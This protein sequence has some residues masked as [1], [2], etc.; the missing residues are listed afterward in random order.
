MKYTI[1]E[2]VLNE[3]NASSKARKDVSYFILNNGF[4]SIG[5]NDKRKIKNNAFAK[6][7]LALKLYV[8]I[9]FTLKKDDVLFLQTSTKVLKPFLLIKKLR[10]FKIIYLI[11]DM[12][13]LRFSQKESI[14]KHQLEIKNDIHLMSQ[15]D[16][17]IA[18][19]PTM[20]ERLRTFGC[21]AKLFSLDI[22]DY[23]TQYPAPRRTH[24]DGDKWYISF[25]GHLP[26][27]QF[28]HTLDETLHSL[29]LIIYGGPAEYFKHAQYK[30][31][32][33]AELLPSTI[34]GHFG[35][36]WEGAYHPEKED[37]Y[38]CINNPHKMSMYIVAGLPII[39]W[40]K[41]A[42]AQFVEA[43]GIGFAIESLDE[44][45]K[46]I[47]M[48]DQPAYEQMVQNCIDLRMSLIEGK[49]IEHVINNIV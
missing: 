42:A 29:Q 45:E 22:F 20:I 26:K 33:D 43:H 32:V 17:V 46:A 19:N 18:H 4:C 38:T 5:Q 41:S 3:Y 16:Y 35:L 27:S 12:F 7:L 24:K 15:C 47:S 31:T 44:I 39:C 23:H 48:I 40:K 14:A 11:H 13:S 28:L 8:K 49:H 9:L 10:S 34:E 6:S 37:N 25:A 2:Y 36:I 1:E 30:G 21:T